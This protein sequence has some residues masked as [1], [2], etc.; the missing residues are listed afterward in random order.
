VA[1][2]PGA[3]T[4]GRKVAPELRQFLQQQLPEHMIPW[5]FVALD[6]F[7]LTSNGKLDRSA[8]P[9]PLALPGEA[10]QFV[11]PRD[12]TERELARIWSEVLNVPR[13]SVNDDFFDLGGHSILAG[14]VTSRVR[15]VFGIDLSFAEVFSAPTLE[16]MAGVIRPRLQKPSPQTGP[17]AR[18]PRRQRRTPA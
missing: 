14:R 17:I 5:A 11:A 9:A 12:E 18:A 7:P 8:L 15:T 1:S 2:D 3:A 10:E 4:F 6:R 16:R 13:I